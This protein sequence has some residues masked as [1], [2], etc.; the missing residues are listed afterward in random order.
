MGKKPNVR[1]RTVGVDIKADI[2]VNEKPLFY[3]GFR[4][5]GQWG[6]TGQCPQTGT[7]GH[8]GVC[9]NTPYMSGH[10]AALSFFLFES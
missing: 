6:W 10:R 2:D 7:I 1:P 3:R 8:R 4:E 5:S 9:V